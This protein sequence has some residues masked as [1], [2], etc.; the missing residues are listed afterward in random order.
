MHTNYTRPE[1]G[2]FMNVI[3]TIVFSAVLLYAGQ[4]SAVSNMFSLGKSTGVIGN[5]NTVREKPS[6][7]VVRLKWEGSGM[8]F[9]L[10]GGDPI[11]SLS[12]IDINGRVVRIFRSTGD[13]TILWNGCGPHGEMLPDGCYM[14]KVNER[15]AR[16]FI[17]FGRGMG[18]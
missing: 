16:A 2:T 11:Y 5:R 7:P 13:K 3:V 12:I 17:L 18:K 9:S 6:G 4:D 10:R 15:Y 14:L 8:M 1:T